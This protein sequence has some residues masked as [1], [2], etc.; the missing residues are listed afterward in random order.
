MALSLGLLY[1]EEWQAISAI[2]MG[3]A[4]VLAVARKAGKQGLIKNRYCTAGA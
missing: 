2:L 3:D 1:C 4:A